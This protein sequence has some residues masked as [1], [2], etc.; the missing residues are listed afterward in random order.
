MNDIMWIHKLLD[1]LSFFYS[2]QQPTPLHCNNQ[3]AIQLTKN[4]QFHARTKHINVHFH[5]VHQAA[6]LDHIQVKYV[7]TDEMVADI[8]TKSLG[9]I[10]FKMFHE[11]L[12]VI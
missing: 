2:Y 3:G 8:F 6:N 5:F 9:C 1:K 7:P 4:S 10:K 11:I 12:N